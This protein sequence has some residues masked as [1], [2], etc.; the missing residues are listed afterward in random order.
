[1]VHKMIRD[2]NI[3]FLCETWLS[4][5]DNSVLLSLFKNKRIFT[6]TDYNK[7]DNKRGRPFGGSAWIIDLDIEIV[8]SGWI[9]NRVSTVEINKNGTNL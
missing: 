8:D 5:E 2:T 7:T 3:L 9:K 6:Y 4:A 1:M